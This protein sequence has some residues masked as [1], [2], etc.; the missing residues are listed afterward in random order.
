LSSNFLHLGHWAVTTVAEHKDGYRVEASYAVQP[1]SCPKCGVDGELYRH[2]TLEQAVN[3]TTH[4]GKPV[5]VAWKRQRYRCKACGATF[6]QPSPDVDDDRLMTRRLREYIEREVLRRTFVSVGNEVGVSEGT[7]RNVFRAYAERLEAS[8]RFEAP[9]LLGIDELYIRGTP[10]CIMTNLGE[11]CVLDFMESRSQ[12]AVHHALLRLENRERV[13][14]VAIDMHRPYRSAVNAAL[15]KAI[16]VVDKFHVVRMATNSLDALR[17]LIGK[18]MTE[19][20]RRHV[21]RNRA[22][23]LRRPWE[24]NDADKLQLSEWLG[25]LPELATAYG[26]KE[27]FFDVWESAGVADARKRLHGW[28]DAIPANLRDVFKPL[29]TA[30]T[31]WE[32]EI[33]NYFA[34]EGVTN[35]Y[36]ES[37]NRTLRDMDRAG[38][39]YSFE[40]LRVKALFAHGQQKRRPMRALANK[41]HG[42]RDWA[43]FIVM[44]SPSTEIGVPYSTFVEAVTQHDDSP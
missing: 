18:G 24:L 40:V 19:R 34:T 38:R 32:A 5:I 8:H 26:L 14:I 6:L 11:H 33:L 44:E 22:I 31:N 17:K 21:M 12:T 4:S 29:I 36:T 43:G 3:D 15:P 7:I 42:T 1:S 16:V 9:E 39:G 20:R 30:S 10:R 25:E 35:A 13:R 28:R 27:Q 41:R 23:L 37:A 2:G